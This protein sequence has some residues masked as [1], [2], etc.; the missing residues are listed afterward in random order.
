ML[1]AGQNFGFFFGNK[2]VKKFYKNKK[3]INVTHNFVLLYFCNF[4]LLYYCKKNHVSNCIV[5]MGLDSLAP[6]RKHDLWSYSAA[7]L[8]PILHTALARQHI[9]RSAT[10]YK[11]AVTQVYGIIFPTLML[12]HRRL[13]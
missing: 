7:I 9:P 12:F 13:A 2:F 11:R 5:N 1:P 3:K 10:F 8:L 6:K 4:E